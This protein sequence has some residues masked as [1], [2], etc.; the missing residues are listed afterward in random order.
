MAIY[1][2]TVPGMKPVLVRDSSKAKAVEQLV[3]I[4]SLTAEEMQDALE[5]GEKVFKEGDRVEAEPEPESEGQ[6]APE[7]E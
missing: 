3:T 2:M 6:Q 1:R 7:K 5:A 4:E